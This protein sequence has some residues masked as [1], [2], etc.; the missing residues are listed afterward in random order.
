MFSRECFMLICQQ[1]HKS[2][3]NYHQITDRPLFLHET[4]GYV[5]QTR[6]R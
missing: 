5:Q 1:T 3:Q 6:S 2:H 4:I